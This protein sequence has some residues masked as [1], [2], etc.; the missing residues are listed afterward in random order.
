MIPE[1]DWRNV[2]TDAAEVRIFEALEDPRWEWRTVP[3]LSRASG[4]N[5]ASV[6]KVL[7]KYRQFIRQSLAASDSGED[8][9]ILHERRLKQKSIWEKGWEFLGPSSSSST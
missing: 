1:T 2:V 7:N 8:L 5:D 9:F 4:L 3:A 6:R